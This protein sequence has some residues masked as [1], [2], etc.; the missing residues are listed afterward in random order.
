VNGVQWARLLNAKGSWG[1]MTLVRQE[2]GAL[3]PS[4]GLYSLR[5][6]YGE[7]TG[8][9][10]WFVKGATLPPV[11]ISLPVALPLC[12]LLEEEANPVSMAA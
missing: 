3:A 5:G 6:H 10:Q 8:I 2:Q 1:L 12:Y 7:P 9:T 11:N 4:S